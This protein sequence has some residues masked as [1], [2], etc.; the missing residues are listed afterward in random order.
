MP[1]VDPREYI[2]LGEY[3]QPEAIAATVAFLASEEASYL[4]GAQIAVDGGFAA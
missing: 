2:A 3:A 4:T 1:A